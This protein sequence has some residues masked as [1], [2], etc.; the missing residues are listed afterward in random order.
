MSPLFFL[1]M[2]ALIVVVVLLLL[3]S[4]RLRE[5]YAALW[6][7]V[8]LASIVLAAF[9]ALLEWAA[10]LVGFAVPS[11]LMFTLA[12][13]LLL[14]VC[15]HLSLELSRLEDETRT[16]AE[17]VAVL[18]SEVREL[19]A[20]EAIRSARTPVVEDAAAREHAPRPRD[21]VE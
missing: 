21:V 13:V 8:G 20:A 9:P 6:I 10:H 17:G 5:K 11:N 19:R 2:A 18:D 1:A 14:G 4:R 12:I 15:L 16:L 3:R 7:V